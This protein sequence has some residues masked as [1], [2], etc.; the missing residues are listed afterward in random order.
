MITDSDPGLILS[1]RFCLCGISGV[2]VGFLHCVLSVLPY[3]G[4]LAML[5]CPYVRMSVSMYMNGTH[6]AS[7]FVPSVPRIGSGSSGH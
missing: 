2:C 5:D 1:L 3:C 4:G 6:Q 7:C